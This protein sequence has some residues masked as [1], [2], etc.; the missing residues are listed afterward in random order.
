MDSSPKYSVGDCGLTAAANMHRG[1]QSADREISAQAGGCKVPSSFSF[2][3]TV[4]LQTSFKGWLSASRPPSTQIFS[5]KTTHACP[6]R[7]GNGASGKSSHP[8]SFFEFFL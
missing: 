7:G 3:S 1:D 2:G 5:L 4:Q 8:N 6:M